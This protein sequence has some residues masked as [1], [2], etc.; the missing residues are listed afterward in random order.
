MACEQC[1]RRSALVSAVGHAITH[2]SAL[3]L[4]EEQLL[5]VTKAKNRGRPPRE[6]QTPTP[7][8]SVPTALCRHDPDYP[9]VLTQ[10]DYAPAVLYAT[11]TVERLRELL[12]KPTVAILGERY[13]SDYAHEIA[14]ALA[15]DLAAAGVTVISWPETGLH[16]IAHHG[17]LEAEGQTIAVM[18]CAPDLPYG[19]TYAHL[20][21][22]IMQRGAVISELPPGFYP[23]QPWCYKA[24]QRIIAALSSVVVVVEVKE[25]SRELLIAQS[26]SE[27]GH[28]IAVVPGR[29]TDA[30]GP[31][32]FG[33]LRDGAHAVGCAEDVLELI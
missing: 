32:T 7:S 3:G 24:R 33:L 15:H 23:P 2:P 30:G 27:L 10:L 21:Q 25:R 22:C 1:L 28:E 11:C 31:A 20:H 4:R 6:L 14:F 16:A 19:Q 13:H 29:V 9:Q 26:A 5:R 17:A 12:A 8:E 18:P